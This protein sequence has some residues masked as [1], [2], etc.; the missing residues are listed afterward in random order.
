MSKIRVFDLAAKL[1]RSPEELREELR[2]RGKSVKS[3]LSLLEGPQVDELMAHYGGATAKASAPSAVA[4]AADKAKSSA[5][6]VRPVLRSSPGGVVRVAPAKPKAALRKPEDEAGNVP[7]DAASAP[8]AK[9]ASPSGVIINDRPDKAPAPPQPVAPAA[10]KPAPAPAPSLSPRPKPLARPL[11]TVSME[12]PRYDRPRPAGLSA[13]PT[14][15]PDAPRNQGRVA[16]K[17]S[18]TAGSSSTNKPPSSA[19][20]SAS[21]RDKKKKKDKEAELEE[22]LFGK[23]GRPLQTA[24]SEIAPPPDA[25]KLLK[26]P[27]GVSV[28]ELAQAMHIKATDII[29]KLMMDYKVMAT[30]NQKLTKDV[31]ETLSLDFGFEIQ[32]EG[33][34]GEDLLEQEESD[35]AENLVPRGPV[36]TIMGHVDHGKTT[37]LD[38]IRDSSVASGEHGGIT[39][40]IGAYKVQLPKHEGFHGGDVVF[41]DTPGHAAFTAMRARGAKATDIVV[42]VVAADDSVMPQT[43]EAIAHAKEAKVPMVVAINKV[44]KEGANPDRVMQEL[45]THGLVPEAWGGDTVM[46]KVSA[47][48]RE[49][50]KELLEML[51][52]QSDILEL[53]ADPKRRAKGVVIEAKLDKGRGSVA[54]VLVQKGTL[55]VGDMLV[56]GNHSGRVRALHDDKG[57]KIEQAGPSTPVEVLGMSGVPEAGDGFQAVE[58][59]KLARQISTKRLSVQQDRERAERGHIKLETLFDRIEAGDVK[60]L[61]IVIKADMSG[62]VEALKHSLEDIKSDKV[63]PHVILGAVGN[64]TENDVLLAA[65]SDAIVLGFHVKAVGQAVELAH[66]EKVEVRLYQVIYEAVDDVRAAMTGLLEPHFREVITGRGEIRQLFKISKGQ[67]AGVYIK[68]GKIHRDSIIRIS[69]AEEKIWEGKISSLKRFKDDARE[70]AEGTECGVGLD[71]SAKVEVG[72]VFEILTQEEVAQKI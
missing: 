18:A 14:T 70:V 46:M 1:G 39:Q 9:S 65:A 34:F 4:D 64:I 11:T 36:V 40:H 66:R 13:A 50:V 53:K 51:V 31:V 37:L 17:P 48:K 49:G 30:V 10:P 41:L 8:T 47:K 3:N 57:V 32:H 24:V 45:S 6:V 52:L 7:L 63:R 12:I 15:R 20:F 60:E 59:E 55:K 38:A 23:G 72:D 58:N 56:M 44:D 61:K 69:R 27:E 2:K 19:S 42:L 28:S 68:E 22:K 54:T 25:P 71:P 35:K 33:L 21:K 62:S 16:P 29:R 67:F 43:I 5:H 26:L